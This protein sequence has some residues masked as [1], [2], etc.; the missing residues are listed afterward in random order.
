MRRAFANVTERDTHLTLG[1]LRKNFVERDINRR[2]ADISDADA[3]AKLV[4]E[5]V[6]DRL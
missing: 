4:I 1:K 2:I 5:P 6:E 3:G